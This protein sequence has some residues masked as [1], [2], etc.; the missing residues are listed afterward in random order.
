V[1]QDLPREQRS[2]DR[3]D[4]RIQTPL[5]NNLDTHEEGEE[6]DEL[7]PEIHCIEDTSPFP[8]LTQSAY[9]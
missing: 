5:Q 7:D 3:D 2:K 9:E 1:P 8:H 4:H 6:I